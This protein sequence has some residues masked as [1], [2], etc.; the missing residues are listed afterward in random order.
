MIIRNDMDVSYVRVF[1]ASPNAPAVDVYINK[2][3]VF[4]NISFKDFSEYI[5]LSKG[6][7]EMEVYPANQ[8]NTPVITE[9]IQVPEK[10]VITVAIAGNLDDLQVVP[11]IEG[12]AEDLP[13]NQ[14]RV[15]AI[16]LS[17][18]APEVDILVN[19]NLAF[20]DVGFLDASDYIQLP[21]AIYDVTINIADTQDIVLSLRPDFK[22]QKVYTI[23]IV[24]NPPDLSGIQSLD[25]ITF[26]RFI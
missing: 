21:S 25:G 4:S 13:V 10:Q 1:H 12:N 14:S 19:N 9:N 15:R 23:Y 8:K 24:G 17:P 26:I 22:S 5:P 18:D 3:L 20:D 2:A 11:Y 16:H 6:E 7:Y